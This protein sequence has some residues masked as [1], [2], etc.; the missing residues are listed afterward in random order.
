MTT[1]VFHKVLVPVEFVSFDQDKVQADRATEVGD[2]DWVGVGPDTVRALELAARLVGDDGELW[3]VHAHHDF[4]Q[5]ATWMNPSN[6]AQ[7]NAG[8]TRYCTTVLEAVA[9]KHCPHA[10]LHYVIE[11]GRPL[12]VILEVAGEHP[13]DAIVLAASSRDRLNRAFLGSTADKVIRRAG[14]PVLV[15]PS[16]AGPATAR[17]VSQP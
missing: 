17:R 2:H 7:L 11:P 6:T 1:G 10:E 14:C 3:L 15:V 8:A 12:D 4:A 9:T 13:P 16:G 5:H